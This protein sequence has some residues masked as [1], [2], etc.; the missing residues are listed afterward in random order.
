MRF[1]FYIRNEIQFLKFLL[2]GIKSGKK[3]DAFAAQRVQ[4]QRR[5]LSGKNSR[6]SKVRLNLYDKQTTRRYTRTRRCRS[7]LGY[8]Y[9][10]VLVLVTL[11]YTRSSS[12]NNKQI[13]AASPPTATVTRTQLERCQTDSAAAPLAA[14]PKKRAPEQSRGS[15]A[16]VNFFYLVF[17]LTF[18]LSLLPEG[19]ATALSLL[20]Q[21]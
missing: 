10:L 8:G 2:V 12:D 13:T 11:R 5:R 1:A 6:I 18:L 7:A 9:L 14:P 17:F 15:A 4:L 21:T 19:V 20:S 16:R 3:R